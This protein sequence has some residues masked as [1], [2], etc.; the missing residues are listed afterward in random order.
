MN[1]IVLVRH[2]QT[3]WSV[4]G[5]HTGRTDI[6]LTDLG[7]RQAAALGAMLG[8]AEFAAVLASPLSRAWDTM[9]GAGYEGEGR[10]LDDL[11]E[12]DYGVYEGSS[13]ADI[14]EEIPMWSVWTH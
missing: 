12:W 2:G 9:A 10:P 5:R 7:R 4:S 14:R 8:G 6:P 11:L 3:E 1:E 13:T